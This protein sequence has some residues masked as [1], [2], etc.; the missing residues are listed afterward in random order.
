VRVA[1]LIGWT[2]RSVGENASD[3][4]HDVQFEWGEMREKQIQQQCD[5]RIGC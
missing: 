1:D 5:G 2:G 3:D 4:E